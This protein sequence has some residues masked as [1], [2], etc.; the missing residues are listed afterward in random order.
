MLIRVAREVGVAEAESVDL[1]DPGGARLE[2]ANLAQWSATP[3]VEV[4]DRFLRAEL[5]QTLGREEEALG[6]YASMAER[7][8]DELAY[9]APA[10]LRQ[11]EIYDHQ[12]DRGRAALH[13][14]KFLQLWEAAEPELAPQVERARARLVILSA[15]TVKE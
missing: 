8:S 9:L 2:G 4:A 3:V 15:E 10:E 13:Y 1:D 11:A 7:S 14:R 12:G 5:L 6:W